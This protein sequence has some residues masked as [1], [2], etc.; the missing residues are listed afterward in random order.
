M[1]QHWLVTAVSVVALVAAG[2]SAD[3]GESAPKSESTETS[4]AYIIGMPEGFA[5]VAFK[6]NGT[7][8][9][10]V[11]EGSGLAVVRND[12]RCDGMEGP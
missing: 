12:D 6:C 2:C 9:I 8:G 4:P 5:N 1:K 7:T 10:Y 3:V 11:A